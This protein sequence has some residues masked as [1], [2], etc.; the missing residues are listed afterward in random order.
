M[1]AI[2]FILLQQ[3][4]ESVPLGIKKHYFLQSF[5]IEFLR[6]NFDLNKEKK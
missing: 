4:A 5:L 2:P 3:Q 1:L 6:K